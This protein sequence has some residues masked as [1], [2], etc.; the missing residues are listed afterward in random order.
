M[1]ESHQ[2]FPWPILR[3]WWFWVVAGLLCAIPTGK[4]SGAIGDRYSLGFPFPS[5]YIKHGHMGDGGTFKEGF[6]YFLDG[7]S[8]PVGGY[9]TGWFF[10]PELIGPII[11]GGIL[12]LVVYAVSKVRPRYPK[13]LFGISCFLLVV[14]VYALSF[15]PV[16]WLCSA[17]SRTGWDG[18]PKAVRLIYGPLTHALKPFANALDCYVQIWIKME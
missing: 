11:N 5:V 1:S 4:S 6:L 14:A 16:L 3:T 7:S 8:Q 2:V 13:I 10:H 12:L 9:R 18:L 15:G 17:T